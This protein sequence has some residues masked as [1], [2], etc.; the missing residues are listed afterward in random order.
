[1]SFRGAFYWFARISLQ[2]EHLSV[3]WN[4]CR[5]HKIMCILWQASLHFLGAMDKIKCLLS[6]KTPVQVEMI[7]CTFISVGKACIF[8]ISSL[9]CLILPNK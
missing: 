7:L 2:T 6:H 3:L 4:V 9:S 8:P 5:V 1:M